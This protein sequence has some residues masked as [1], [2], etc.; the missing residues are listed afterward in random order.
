MADNATTKTGITVRAD[1]YNPASIA[2][3]IVAIVKTDPDWNRPVGDGGGHLVLIGNGNWV[4]IDSGDYV[5]QKG[6]KAF[7]IDATTYAA[8]FQ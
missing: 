3:D 5:V 7:V 1:A 2:T 6:G 8:L 4:K